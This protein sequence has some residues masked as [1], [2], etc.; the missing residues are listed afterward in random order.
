VYP[1]PRVV[2][3][4]EEHFVPVRVHVREQADAFKR[5]GE[6]YDA[7][8]TPTLLVLDA[9]GTEHHRVEGFLPVDDLLAQLILGRAQVAFARKDFASAE[10]LFREVVDT[11][12][13]TDAAAEAQYWAGVSRYKGTGDGAALA[14]TARQFETRYKDTPWAKKASV[15][16][17]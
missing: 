15:W 13:D 8:W 12:G 7:Q 16:A 2:R 1:D 11:H 5:L 6:K 9:D 10:R 4:V 3:F 14:E 17:K